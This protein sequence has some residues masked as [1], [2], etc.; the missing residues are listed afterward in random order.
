[1][2]FQSDLFKFITP[3]VVD[4]GQYFINDMF[5]KKFAGNAPN[6]KHHLVA[7]YK[8]NGTYTPVS[9][10]HFL[11]YKNT[12]LVGGGMTDGRI[13]KT[14]SQGEK[15]SITKNNGVLYFM[16]K[17]GFEH[18]SSQCDA[19]FGHV[20]DPRAL[21]VDLAAGFETTEHEYLVAHFHKPISSW[22]KKK[23]IKMIHKLGNF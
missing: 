21:E 5:Q 8:K 19:Y 17:Y 3:V 11:P 22:K 4:N 14:M 12:L 1:M 2:K 10:L 15:D 20:D 23:M 9:Y 7:F 13:I 6:Y 18:F 16:L